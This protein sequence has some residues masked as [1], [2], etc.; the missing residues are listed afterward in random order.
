MKFFT[1]V[2]AA[3]SFSS[4]IAAPVEKR[5]VQVGAVNSILSTMDTTLA[6][7]AKTSSKKRHSTRNISN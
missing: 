6:Q 7:N 3:L 5:G 2:F 1:A 4:V